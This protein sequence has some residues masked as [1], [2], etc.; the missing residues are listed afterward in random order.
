MPRSPRYRLNVD[1][2]LEA[3]KQYGD[4]RQIDVSKRTGIT[5]DAMS[6]LWNG[7]IFPLDKLLKLSEVY[8]I[9]ANDLAM[10]HDP[11]DECEAAA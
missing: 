6:R 3:A 5:K 9:P 8:R 2:L 4:E 10:K 11:E 1:A 7:E